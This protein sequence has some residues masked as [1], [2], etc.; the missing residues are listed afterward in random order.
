[1]IRVEPFL[2]EHLENLVVQES[3]RHE[4]PTRLR[5]GT[6]LFKGDQILGIVGGFKWNPGVIQIWAILSE[7][8]KKY[9]I[10]F[11]KI[12]LELIDF[13]EQ[14]HSPRR[15]QIDVRVDFERGQRWAESMGF[16][17]EGT[18]KKFASDGSD[19]YLYGKVV[20]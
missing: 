14:Q 5:D 15:L 9:P 19:C 18:M 12:C 7:D 11:H 10:S 16:I 4:K 2:P 13:C 6:T 3:Q 1:M 8:I 20:S 17:R